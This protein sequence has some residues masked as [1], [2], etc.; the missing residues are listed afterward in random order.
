MKKAVTLF[1]AIFISV[2][3]PSLVSCTYG[4]KQSISRSE[5]STAKRFILNIVNGNPE[6]I[7][8]MDEAMK[9]SLT[10]QKQSQIR[11]ALNVSMGKLKVLKVPLTEKYGKYRMVYVPCEFAK[12]MIYGKIVFNGNNKV[13]GL[14]FVRLPK[15]A[16]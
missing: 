6:T 11:Q 10:P 4:S 2:A 7:Q 13:A 14:F 9:I 5:V 3:L 1:V 8:D 16:K 12:G 15:I